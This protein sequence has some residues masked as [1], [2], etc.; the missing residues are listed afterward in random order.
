LPEHMGFNGYLMPLMEPRFQ[1]LV[2]FLYGRIQPAPTFRTLVTAAM[3]LARDL[4]SLHLAGLCYVDLNYNN[5]FCDFTRGEV[6]VCD[7]D[8]VTTDGVDTPMFGVPPFM[9]PEVLR[10]G[11]RPNSR[12]D[13]FSFA[14]ILFQTFMI[15]HPLIGRKARGLYDA[16]AQQR[17]HGAEPLFIFDPADES[18]APVPGDPELGGEALNYWPIYPQFLRDMFV[19]AFTTGLRRPN[20]RKTDLEWL[21]ALSRLRDAIFHCARCGAEN[22]Y[23]GDALSRSGGFPGACWHC[24]QVLTLPPR[25]NLTPG[26]IVVLDPG[27]RLF[28]SHLGM[29][30]DFARALAEAVRDGAG[31]SLRNLSAQKW[32]ASGADGSYQE[33]PPGAAL[34]LLSGMRIY[35]GRVEGDV[36][37]N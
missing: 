25:L 30:A 14:V 24:A 19:E 8:N 21:A 29:G 23:D 31:L 16:A 20:A 22:F 37:S 7:N 6:A 1:K 4:R 3:N 26:Q 18:N 9:A 12:T 2:H 28:P 32:T 33:V 35:F 5:I 27:A 13:L 36:R 34:P 17:L 11:A 10:G 15:S